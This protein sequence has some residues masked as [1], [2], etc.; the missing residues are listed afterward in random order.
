LKLPKTGPR[1]FPFQLRE[2]LLFLRRTPFSRRRRGLHL[3]SSAIDPTCIRPPVTPR[4][5]ATANSGHCNWPNQITVTSPRRDQSRRKFDKVA[6]SPESTQKEMRSRPLPTSPTT[7]AGAYLQLNRNPN[8]GSTNEAGRPLPYP[9]PSASISR[10]PRRRDAAGPGAV[11]ID[12]IDTVAADT[13]IARNRAGGSAARGRVSLDRDKLWFNQAANRPLLPTNLAWVARPTSLV[14][15]CEGRRT[16]TTWPPGVS[17]DARMPRSA[18]YLRRTNSGSTLPRDTT[19]R[20]ADC[21]QASA[22]DGFRHRTA[23]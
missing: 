3:F 5:R 19:L 2:G 10:R 21:A 7:K 11:E 13:S 18:F 8:T 22:Q 14:A 12:L 9:I 15:I 23:I 20:P 1:H 16:A 4:A 17:A 6:Y